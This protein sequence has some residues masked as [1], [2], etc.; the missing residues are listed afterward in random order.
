MGT[1]AT[2]WLTRL[3]FMGHLY[4]GEVSSKSLVFLVPSFAVKDLSFDQVTSSP[5]V[6]QIVEVESH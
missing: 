2:G 5:T 4:F 1:Y 6:E 3:D